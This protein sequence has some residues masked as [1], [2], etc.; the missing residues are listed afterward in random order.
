[1]LGCSKAKQKRPLNNREVN[2]PEGR[3][4]SGVGASPFLEKSMECTK[5]EPIITREQ[6][7]RLYR[8]L[9]DVCD[10]D[11]FRYEVIAKKIA[12][13]ADGLATD[14]EKSIVTD[15]LNTMQEQ[16]RATAICFSKEAQDAG[17]FAEIREGRASNP[18]YQAFLDTLEQDELDSI[19]SNAPF[20]AW[21]SSRLAE[22][23][24][25][26]KPSLAYVRSYA[27]QHLS[28]RVASTREK[29]EALA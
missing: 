9:R 29:G 3:L 16:E 11:S 20:F 24:G 14:W 13:A 25:S 7:S 5:E 27:D 8:F 28:R 6:E 15:W 1:M 2:H 23:G 22:M 18:H 19:Q 17:A 10:G 12:H 26:G 21:M 4:P